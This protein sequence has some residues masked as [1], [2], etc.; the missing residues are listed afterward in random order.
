MTLAGLDFD[1]ER[2]RGPQILAIGEAACSLLARPDVAIPAALSVPTVTVDAIG[3][4]EHEAARRLLGRGG[5]VG[6][7]FAVDAPPGTERCQLE[8]HRAIGRNEPMDDRNDGRS[9][10]HRDLALQNDAADLPAPARNTVCELERC[11]QLVPAGIDRTTP[12]LVGR[13]AK[14]SVARDDDRIERRKPEHAVGR[15]VDRH[16][17]KPVIAAGAQ[18][19]DR[20]HRVAAGTVGDEPLARGRL[21][22][23]PARLRS[24]ADHLRCATASADISSPSVGTGAPR[25]RRISSATRPVQPV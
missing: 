5:A 1:G 12:P 9:V 18:A 4:F 22:E 2:A 24:E 20:P 8:L 14:A 10:R 17:E 21:L 15:P 6:V 19:C 13:E 16:H 7:P 23:C 25:A 11:E 3:A